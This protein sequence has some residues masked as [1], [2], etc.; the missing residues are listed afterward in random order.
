MNI[1]NASDSVNAYIYFFLCVRKFNKIV[2]LMDYSTTLPF[3]CKICKNFVRLRGG[4]LLHVTKMFGS[5][6]LFANMRLLKGKI[7]IKLMVFVRISKY[8]N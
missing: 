5:R 7:F 1:L 3:K 6:N 4:V 8:K 2:L